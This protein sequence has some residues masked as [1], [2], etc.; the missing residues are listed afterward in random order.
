[1]NRK[2]PTWPA[3]SIVTY[4][5][6]YCN[7]NCINCKTNCNK[8]WHKQLDSI[9]LTMTVFLKL[10]FFPIIH[11]YLCRVSSSLGP[12][13]FLGINNH[14]V[15]SDW[16]VQVLRFVW[17]Y[18]YSTNSSLSRY[19]SQL[20]ISAPIPHN[21]RMTNLLESSC[22]ISS[23][24]GFLHLWKGLSMPHTLSIHISKALN[25]LPSDSATV[26]PWW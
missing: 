26:W 7:T 23:S 14:P 6:K 12:Y 11:L 20:M 17:P 4:Q 2:F 1:M 16:D 22:L 3:V 24:E 8:N 13:L 15:D 19:L 25:I 9:C 5:P 21:T 18:F 10:T